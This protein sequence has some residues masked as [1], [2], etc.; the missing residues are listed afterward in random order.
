MSA[1]LIE[2]SAEW[3]TQMLME[4]LTSTSAADWKCQDWK[5]LMQTRSIGLSVDC[6]VDSLVDSLVDENEGWTA[7][8]QI[9]RIGLSIDLKIDPSLTQKSIEWLTEWLT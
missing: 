9:R 7:L 8:M 4:W 2:W 6:V 1:R 3:L 5:S